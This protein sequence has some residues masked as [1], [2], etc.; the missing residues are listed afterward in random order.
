MDVKSTFLNGVVDE[1]V[2][3]EQ[4]KVFVANSC[5]KH[6]YRLK[7][8]L[9]E[10]K[11]AP[12]AWHYFI[13]ELVEDKVILLKHVSIEKQLADIFTKALDA[14]KFKSLRSS[15]GLCVLDK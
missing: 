8:A 9:Y 7:K 12:R 5:P 14:T 6:V 15:F 1:E 2:Y 11:Q 13:R 10:F 4:P 3:V